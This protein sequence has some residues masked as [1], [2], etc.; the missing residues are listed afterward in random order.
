MTTRRGAEGDSGLAGA[1]DHLA[2][3]TLIFALPLC[4]VVAAKSA[5]PVACVAAVFCLASAITR[6]KSVVGAIR[7]LAPRSLIDSWLAAAFVAWAFLSLIWTINRPETAH[8]LGESIIVLAAS[9]ILFAGLAGYRR[10][11]LLR[12]LCWSIILC[13]A[14]ILI[15]ARFDLPLRR[16][17]GSRLEIPQY[18]RAVEVLAIMAVPVMMATFR[19]RP[20]PLA[21]VTVLAIA[22]AAYVVDSGASIFALMIAIASVLTARWS[23][24]ALRRLGLVVTLFLLFSAPLAGTF[25]DVVIPKTGD[26]STLIRRH[27]DAR[28]PIWRAHGYVATQHAALGVG[29]NAA[30]AV[31][32]PAMLAGADPDL[33]DLVAAHSH[34]IFLQVWVE[35]GLVGVL[36][37][38]AL[39]WR[40]FHN[41]GRAPPE[42]QI[43]LLIFALPVEAIAL[44]AHSAWQGAWLAAIGGALAILNIAYPAPTDPRRAAARAE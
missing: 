12:Y 6:R 18:K 33:R 8:G 44:V 40:A 30:S 28:I 23:I 17:F 21:C 24:D 43:A 38:A 4:M 20:Q 31:T 9:W 37:F 42:R 11:P 10:E 27:I 39:I 41:I 15:E 35:L 13:S 16:F 34:H 14:L 5:V 29:F 19:H 1:L 7:D 3:G 2:R 26:A 36:L 25:F 22:I 32:T